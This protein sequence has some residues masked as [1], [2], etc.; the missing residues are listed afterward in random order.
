MT[1]KRFSTETCI[2]LKPL[3]LC[4]FSLPVVGTLKEYWLEEFV[5]SKITGLQPASMLKATFFRVL[6]E[7][8]YIRIHGRTNIQDICLGRAYS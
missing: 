8:S 4:S 1:I 5:S 3:L 2:P 7:A 6:F